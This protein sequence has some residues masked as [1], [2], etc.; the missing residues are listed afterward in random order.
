MKSLLQR[1]DS[2]SFRSG[3]NGAARSAFGGTGRVSS[4]LL[5][6]LTLDT[7][8]K[9]IE[10]T[11]LCAWQHILHQNIYIADVCAGILLYL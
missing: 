9:G 7:L 6:V 3:R 1:F 11:T 10:K 8:Q 4:H 5:E 2:L